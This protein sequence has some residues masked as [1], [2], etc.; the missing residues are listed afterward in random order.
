MSIFL[1]ADIFTSRVIS[2]P[3]LLIENRGNIMV[4][5]TAWLEISD[6]ISVCQLDIKGSNIEHE[7]DYKRKMLVDSLVK[8]VLMHGA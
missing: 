6:L 1:I 8:T 7:H 5:S 3:H 4:L 2:W